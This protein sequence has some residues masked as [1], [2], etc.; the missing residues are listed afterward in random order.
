MLPWH[1]AR[2][3]TRT[4]TYLFSCFA[5]TPRRTYRRGC[6]VHFHVPGAEECTLAFHQGRPLTALTWVAQ[7]PRLGAACSRADEEADQLAEVA[8]VYAERCEHVLGPC[9]RLPGANGAPGAGFGGR[10]S[11]GGSQADDGFMLL[12]VRVREGERLSGHSMPYIMCQILWG[13]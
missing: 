9:D 10:S 4:L 5:I 2:L 7:Q 8:S 3:A 1:G 6:S 12:Q 13:L 11:E